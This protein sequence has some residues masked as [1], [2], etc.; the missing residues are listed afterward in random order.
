[1]INLEQ[2]HEFAKWLS[3][4]K[5]KVGQARILARIRAAGLGQFVDCEPVGDRVYEMRIHCG[6]AIGFT[7]PARESHLPVA[8][9]RRQNNPGAR[10][11]TRT[12]YSQNIEL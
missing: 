11:K 9:W 5:D 6:Q 8:H 12:T 2:T 7:A 10:H 4:L 1:M 3:S